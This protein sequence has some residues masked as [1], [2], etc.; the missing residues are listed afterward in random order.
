MPSILEL[1]PTHTG[2]ILSSADRC[3]SAVPRK[4]YLV[5]FC[6]FF[7]LSLRGLIQCPP[8]NVGSIFMKFPIFPAAALGIFCLSSVPANAIT[9]DIGDAVLD[10]G[11]KFNGNTKIKF[12]PN[13]VGTAT[14]TFASVPGQQYVI[15]V[16]GHN[17]QSTSYFNFFIDANGPAA[18]GFVQLGGN[19]NFA[20]GF[21]T[22][23]LPS[24][25]DVG[26]VDYFQIVSGGTGN[27]AGQIDAVSVSPLA[28]PG[29]V[30]GAGLPGVVMAVGGLLA[31]RRRRNQS[32]VA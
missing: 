23:A 30:V 8:Y 2:K 3:K 9:L 7:L 10:G 6:H 12:D 13:E 31:W 28:V 14:F 19:Y 24:F 4:L 16:N 1:V 17:D 26:T 5:D 27:L 32:A 18:G 21:V 22:I 20:P 11:A 25:T 15:T 29:P